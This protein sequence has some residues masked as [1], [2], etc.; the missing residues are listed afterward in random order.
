[1]TPTPTSVSL[2]VLGEE[3]QD[4]NDEHDDA[5]DNAGDGQI[6]RDASLELGAV[7]VSA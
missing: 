3:E 5:D 4:G 2:R 7:P 6:H 1:M